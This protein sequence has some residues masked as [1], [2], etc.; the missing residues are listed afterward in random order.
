MTKVDGEHTLDSILL[1]HR[2][3]K[4]NAQSVQTTLGGGQLG[5]LALVIS[6]E[7]YNTIPNATL[8]V[9]PQDPG[10]FE[11]YL[12]T[13]SETNQNEIQTPVPSS[14][15]TTRSTSRATTSPVQEPPV[16]TTNQP[17]VIFSVEVATQKAAHNNAERKYYE[18]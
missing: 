3:V 1:L 18:C 12:P 16:Q 10:K 6:E 8:F 15:R 2:Q 17:T 13:S 11:V 4:I 9:H 14:R 7:K 5:Y